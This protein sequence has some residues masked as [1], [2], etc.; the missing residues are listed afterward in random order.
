[1]PIIL[2]IQEAKI[3]RTIVQRQPGQIFVRPY[4]PKKNPSQKRTGGVTKGIDP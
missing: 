2:A 3:R 4:P 1:M